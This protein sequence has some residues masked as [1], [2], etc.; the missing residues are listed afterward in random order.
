MPDKVVNWFSH[1]FQEAEA[2]TEI[3]RVELEEDDGAIVECG[4]E[5]IISLGLFY[6]NLTDK[7]YKGCETLKIYIII[8]IFM[9]V[10]LSVHSSQVFFCKII[11]SNH[12]CSYVVSTRKS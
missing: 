8:S 2:V 1:Q 4:V 6:I 9:S 10:L 5:H 7:K 12:S 11:K 3:P